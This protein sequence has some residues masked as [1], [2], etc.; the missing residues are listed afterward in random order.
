L[1]RDHDPEDGR[2]HAEVENYR[3]ALLDGIRRG[4]S[5]SPSRGYMGS[6]S[7]SS[8]ALSSSPRNYSDG[9]TSVG[10]A[11]LISGADQADGL[12]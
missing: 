6:S 9:R 7:C 8:S 11:A 1:L 2:N 5:T 4:A 3:S 10:A 12:R